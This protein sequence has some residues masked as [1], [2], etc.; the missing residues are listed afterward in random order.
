MRRTKEPSGLKPWRGALQEEKQWHPGFNKDIAF[1]VFKP[2]VSISEKLH[3]IL[4]TLFLKSSIDDKMRKS[5][6]S[7]LGLQFGYSFWCILLVYQKLFLKLV[8]LKDPDKQVML[9]NMVTWW[10]LG[11]DLMD[12]RKRYCLL[13]GNYN[14]LKNASLPQIF[15]ESILCAKQ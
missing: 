14:S 5:H 9:Y 10:R 15:M 13:N 4:L 12:T 8:T 3:R 6:A 1:S 2:R 7:L 11:K